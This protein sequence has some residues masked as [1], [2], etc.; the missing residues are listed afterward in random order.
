MQTPNTIA[1]PAA[2]QRMLWSATT[3]DWAS[4]QEPLMRPWYEAILDAKA[5]AMRYRSSGVIE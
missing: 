4:Y 1:D 5:I 2:F 3:K